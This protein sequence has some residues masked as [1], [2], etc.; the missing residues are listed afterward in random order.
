MG[1]FVDKNLSLRLLD[2][3]GLALQLLDIE[4]KP[5]QHERNGDE[6]HAKTDAAMVALNHR[7]LAGLQV[8]V[9]DLHAGLNIL[10]DQYRLEAVDGDPSFGERIPRLILIEASLADLHA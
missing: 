2:A 10:I 5:D 6:T 3:L 4:P 9:G 8:R 7:V 1:S